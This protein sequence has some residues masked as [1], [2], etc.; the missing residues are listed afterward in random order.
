MDRTQ[1]DPAG[2]P[3]HLADFISRQYGLHVQ[4]SKFVL[5]IT[6]RFSRLFLPR[7]RICTLRASSR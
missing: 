3:E 5:R 4:V 2:H 1:D 6:I 7:V